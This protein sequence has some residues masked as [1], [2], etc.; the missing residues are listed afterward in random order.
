MRRLRSAHFDDQYG[1]RTVIATAKD[2]IRI[3]EEAL[4]DLRTDE[5]RSCSTRGDDFALSA[6]GERFTSRTEAGK[7][8][9]A[10]TYDLPTSESGTTVGSI[11]RFDLIGR[12]R[13]D[14][15]TNEIVMEYGIKLTDR[16][17]WPG[18]KS[19]SVSPVGVIRTLE[20]MVAKVPDL[21]AQIQAQLASAKRRL[22]DATPR[23]RSSFDHE[24]E[25]EA[26]FAELAHVEA[27]LVRESNEAEAARKARDSAKVAAAT[28]DTAIVE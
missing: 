4:I 6:F 21:V 20:N 3:A 8:L 11:G 7:H 17:L 26:K 22:R 2:Q 18:N 15:Q 16:N 28:D 23:V 5:A 19:D 27:E 24:A 1:L 14:Y 10:R 25:L 13:R 12:P 9:V